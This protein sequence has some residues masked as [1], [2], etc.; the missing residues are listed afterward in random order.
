MDQDPKAEDRVEAARRAAAERSKALRS[1]VQTTTPPRRPAPPEQ[2]PRRA[3]QTAPRAAPQRPQPPP[4]QQPQ[5]QA[6][7][8]PRPTPALASRQEM[9]AARE[10]LRDTTNAK[11]IA[12]QLQTTLAEFRPLLKQAADTATELRAIIGEFKELLGPLGDPEK[13]ERFA[14]LIG[15]GVALPVALAEVLAPHGG[16]PPTEDTGERS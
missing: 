4:Q 7:A 15:T 8:Q 10:T 16:S 9:A 14:A 5:A 12:Q 6:Q 11:L 3:Q 13:V 2:A 1:G